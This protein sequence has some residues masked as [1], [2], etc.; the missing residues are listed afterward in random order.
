MCLGGSKHVFSEL[1]VHA[2][3]VVITI[4]SFHLSRWLGSNMMMLGLLF[5]MLVFLI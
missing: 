2:V 4:A 1:V 5:F 3:F